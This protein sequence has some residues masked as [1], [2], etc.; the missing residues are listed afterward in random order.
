M[1]NSI[2]RIKKWVG[3]LLAALMIIGPALS[4]AQVVQAAPDNTK[5]VLSQVYGGGGNSG[6][7]YKNDFIELYNP[8][9]SDVLLT[10]WK[11]RYNSAANPISSGTSTTLSGSIKAKGYYLIQQ[12]AG[13]GGTKNLPSPN[14][15]GTLALSGTNGKVDLVDASGAQ[16]DLIG[17]GTANESEGAATAALT[18]TTAAIRK[19]AAG[20][21]GLDT[22]N[23]S[24]DFMVAS[25]DPRNSTY[26]FTTDAVTASPAPNAWPLNTQL[27]LSSTTA[28]SSVYAEVYTQ[29]GTATGIFQPNTT[30]VM[31]DSPKTIRTYASAPGYSDSSISTFEY[32]I[33]GKT[34]VATARTAAKSRNVMTQGTVTHID[35]QE[36][37]IQDTTGGIVLYS[38]PSFA[39]V[40]DI[41]EVSG[42]MDIYNNL[43]EIKP[44]TGL[45]YSVVQ[46]N[47]GVPAP[48]L[49]T[50]ADLSTANGEQHEAELVY[51]ENVNITDKS[52]STVTA[53]QGG[54]QFT[55]Y[56][57]FPK[58]AVGKTFEKITGV[59]KQF[60]AVYQFI[61]L[62]ENALV[63]ETFS[64]V[65][66]PSA[67]RIIRGNQVM[68][69]SPTVGAAIYYTVDGTVPT[70]TSPLYAAP[71]TVSQDVTIK[72]IAK[73]GEQTSD[74]FTFTYIASEA[75]RIHDIQ[76]ESH[77]SEY[78][79]QNVTDVEGIVTQYGYT[80]ATGAYKGF[81]MQDP[82]PDSNVNTSEGIY[83][84]TTDAFSK[85]AIGDKI[86]VTGTVAEYNEGSGSNLTS[87]QISS[88]TITVLSSGNAIPSAV[89]LGKGG[90]AIPSS[91]VDNDKMMNFQPAEDAIDFYE[92]LEGMLVELP[93]P[94]I[95][96]PYWTSGTGNSLLYN[97]P[98]RVENDVPDVITPAG[99][100]VLKELGNLNPQ[101]LLIAYG[102]PGQEVSSGDRF[103]GDVTGVIGYNNGNYKVIPALNSLPAIIN[104]TFQR[105]TT[106]LTFHEDK[107]TIAGYNIENFNPG[108]GLE[109]INKIAQSIVA[110]MKTP[111]IVGVV[112]MQD[113]N[114]E[115]NDGTVEANM[116]AAALIQAIQNAGGPV[117]QY[118]DIAP[119]NNQDGGAPGGNIR[120]GFLY[121]PDRVTLAD[122]VN[123]TKGSSTTKV[124]YISTGDMLNFNP[125][126]I[127]PTNS[128]FASS[129]KPLAAQF[130]FKGEKVIVIANHFNSKGGDNGPFGNIQP[131]VLSSETQRHQIAA[132]VNGFVKDVLIANPA[133]NIVALGDLNDFQFTQTAT[134]LKGKELDNL[135]DKL[136]INER[137]TY[138]F[139]GNSQVLDHMLVSKKLTEVSKVDVIHLNADFSP[140]DGRVSDH[141]AVLAQI[142]LKSLPLPP[143]NDTDGTPTS[144]TGTPNSNS[145]AELSGIAVQETKGTTADGRSVSIVSVSKDKLLEVLNTLPKET[146]QLLLE[147]KSTDAVVKFELPAETLSE[148]MAKSPQVGITVKSAAGT[149]ILPAKGL[150]ISDLVKTLGNDVKD[151]KIIITIDKVVDAKSQ[152]VDSKV[153]ALGSKIVGAPVDFTITFEANG[154]SVEVNQFT[155][156]V[157]RKMP[158]PSGVDSN[159]VTIVKLDSDGTLVFV[160]AI[161]GN[162]EVELWSCTNSVYAII[163]SNISFADVVSHWAK[164]DVELLAN[165]LVVEGVSSTSF[166]PEAKVTRA[167]FAAMLTRALGLAEDKSSSRFTDVKTS[168]WYAGSVGVAA[169]QGLIEGF[170]NGTFMPNEEITREQMAV[171]VTRAMKFAGKTPEASTPTDSLLAK[172]QDQNKMSTWAKNEITAS[173][174]AS[175]MDG[176][177]DTVFAPEKQATRA[178][179]A[180]MLKRLL[181]YVNFIN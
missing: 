158:I 75:P 3:V 122:S 178:Q 11:V 156:Y 32:T 129:R 77:K 143:V 78:T 171:M 166:S 150:I 123:G 45:T 165:K 83:V 73:L 5:V 102:N 20:G 92:S 174:K 104:N 64:V 41:V 71:I 47:A 8:T 58:L 169:T 144:Q 135:I 87:T 99:G 108:V 25:P 151:V 79:G 125:G 62:N 50:A 160:P 38:F 10:G 48:K 67:G 140:A 21:R 136:P 145:N 173:M 4:D 31:L 131:P 63:E 39:Q 114:G 181:Q 112:E 159:K 69:S 61:P 109:K 18:N 88:P 16:V 124:E 49:L 22:D 163:E 85:P 130:E 14:A 90:R 70:T 28:S 175:I 65:A 137:Y 74:V 121:N 15:T 84:F 27:T 157:A 138:T 26:G 52:G 142:D 40:G 94:T 107:L 111:D 128:A 82:T 81:F 148:L 76:G 153:K 57:P 162:G 43:Q 115:A 6:A 2:N 72:A 68:L 7:E 93:S 146:V 51:L 17:Y 60:N 42:S 19:T 53:S 106:T 33:L 167:Q 116:G 55:I 152:D 110:N 133:A 120:V 118:T 103:N 168:E 24:A 54:Q 56:S 35:E 46:P 95:L 96:S 172:F 13:T 132:L 113:N 12:A 80:F 97:I 155:M 180:V 147:S 179:A 170:E 119:V 37:Y 139:D 1:F 36:M 176:M 44:V 100:L 164:K 23:N 89:V 177:T 117:Y 161:F 86:K 59:I 127:D 9:N 66:N 30:Q 134:I 141:D 154:K 34:D 91:I 98:T 126:R 105:E 101:R 149:Y 29:G